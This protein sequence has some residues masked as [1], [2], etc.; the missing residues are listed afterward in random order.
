M[1][2]RRGAVGPGAPAWG[3]GPRTESMALALPGSKGFPDRSLHACSRRP[4]AHQMSVPASLH[5]RFISTKR[6]S[7]ASSAPIARPMGGGSGVN[8]VWYGYCPCEAAS[9]QDCRAVVF[10]PNSED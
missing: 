8:P 10:L 6:A 2:A 5:S 7:T 9:V 1:A 4:Y 3:G